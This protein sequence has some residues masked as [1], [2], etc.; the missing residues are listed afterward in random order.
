LTERELT[1]GGLNPGFFALVWLIHRP[2]RAYPE[3]P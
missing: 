1:Q 3:R 2:G